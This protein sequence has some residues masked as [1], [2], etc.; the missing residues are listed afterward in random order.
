MD[1]TQQSH[2]AGEAVAHPDADLFPPTEAVVAAAPSLGGKQA[3]QLL[4]GLAVGAGRL[5]SCTGAS[6]RQSA[7][8]IRPAVCRSAAGISAM[9]RARP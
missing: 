4:V 7:Y 8:K 3:L 6:P 2:A 1:S 9:P 5:S